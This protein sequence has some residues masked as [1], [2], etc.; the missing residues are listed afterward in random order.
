MAGGAPAAAAPGF[1]REAVRR[2]PTMVLGGAI[3]LAAAFVA[4]AAPYLGTV[5]PQALS[6]IRRLKPPSEQYWFG[7][8]MLGR[9]LYSRTI[10][11]TR[12]SLIVGFGVAFLSTAVGLA[13]GLV[14][15]LNRVADAI[16]MRVM[17]GLMAIPSVLLAIALMALT[18]ASLGN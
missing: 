15:G 16:V 2:H 9:D 8:D 3:L 7:T 14:T 4:L 18:R 1:V 17:D 12:V 5:D 11:G 10:Y 6:P 13:I